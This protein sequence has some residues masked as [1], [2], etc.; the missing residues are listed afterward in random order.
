VDLRLKAVADRTVDSKRTDQARGCLAL[1][2]VDEIF[3]AP[4]LALRNC[5]DA[6]YEES[7]F[8]VYDD[9]PDDSDAPPVVCFQRKLHGVFQQ[10]MDLRRFPFDAQEPTLELISLWPTE[11]TRKCPGGVCEDA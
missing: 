7:W 6:K 3:F 1:E 8:V 11:A 10:R 9:L 2:G 5:G 4:R